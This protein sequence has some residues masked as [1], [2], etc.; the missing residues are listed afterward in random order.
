MNKDYQVFS[1]DIAKEAARRFQIIDRI[2][3]VP[4]PKIISWEDIPNEDRQV[5]ISVVRSMIED[6]EIIPGTIYVKPDPYEA[7]NVLA[8]KLPKLPRIGQRYVHEAVPEEGSAMRLHNVVEVLGVA[9]GS[10][11]DKS[12]VKYRFPF[13]EG[14]SEYRDSLET[15]LHNRIPLTQA[16]ISRQ[17]EIERLMMET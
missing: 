5:Y 16:E 8:E 13:R 14:S 15:F 10:G 9:P 4:H 1:E 17:K 12:L 7:Y 3:K 11:T 2:G 6:G